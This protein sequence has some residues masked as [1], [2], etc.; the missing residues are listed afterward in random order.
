M[1]QPEQPFI[2][3]KSFPAKAGEAGKIYSNLQQLIS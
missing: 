2:N 3:Q 1:F